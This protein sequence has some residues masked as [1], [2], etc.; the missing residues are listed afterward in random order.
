MTRTGGPRQMRAILFVAAFAGSLVLV[1]CGSSGPATESGGLKPQGRSRSLRSCPT[2]KSGS[3][4]AEDATAATELVPPGAVSAL[5]CRYIRSDEVVRGKTAEGHLDEHRVSDPR[6]VETISRLLV[7]LPKPPKGEY[8]CT[9]A[10]YSL[11]YLVAF[12]YARGAPVFVEIRDVGSNCAYVQGA[13]GNLLFVPTSPLL[14]KLD[15]VL[16]R[17]RPVKGFG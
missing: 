14:E 11:R 4:V 2:G 1:A 3:V 17:Q 5:V 16:P 15:S 10:G 6:T 8:T 12:T 7:S 13:G 9:E